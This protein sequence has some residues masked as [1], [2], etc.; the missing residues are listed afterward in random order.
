[1]SYN[2]KKHLG[3]FEVEKIKDVEKVGNLHLCLNFDKK[4]IL[5]SAELQADPQ[6]TVILSL[7]IHLSGISSHKTSSETCS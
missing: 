4:Q 6:I 2:L 7:L 1:M 5:E 3:N